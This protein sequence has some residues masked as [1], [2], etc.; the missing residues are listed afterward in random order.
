MHLY[1]ELNADMKSMDSFHVASVATDATKTHSR[2]QFIRSVLCRKW[3]QRESNILRESLARERVQI[4][5]LSRPSTSPGPSSNGKNPNHLQPSSSRSA[6]HR[7]L[8]FALTE[9]IPTAHLPSVPGAHTSI[10]SKIFLELVI[11]F[12]IWFFFR[13]QGLCLVCPFPTILQF[14]IALRLHRDTLTHTHCC[15][16]GYNTQA[17]HVL[18][19]WLCDWR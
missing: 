1:I 13:S 18:A 9:C 3:A 2:P 5:H 11:Y 7:F 8:R 12:G 19:L 10:D 15:W 4:I 6:T 17:F 14:A 16:C